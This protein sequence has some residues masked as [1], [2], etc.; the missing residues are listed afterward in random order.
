VGV[1]EGI[2]QL[3]FYYSALLTGLALLRFQTRLACGSMVLSIASLFV[4]SLCERKK[5]TTKRRKVLP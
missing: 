3:L 2:I 5:R 1:M 4:F